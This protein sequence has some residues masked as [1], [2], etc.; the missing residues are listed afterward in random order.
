M[1]QYT[2]GMNS[3]RN[4]EGT[5]ILNRYGSELVLMNSWSQKASVSSERMPWY[6]VNISSFHHQL[7][8]S[9]KEYL[10]VVRVSM[11]LNQDRSWDL[12]TSNPLLK[13]QRVSSSA[14]IT[15]AFEI[16]EIAK[17]WYNAFCNSWLRSIRFDEG[18]YLEVLGEYIF[19]FSDVG[20][21]ILTVDG[22]SDRYSTG[23]VKNYRIVSKFLSCWHKECYII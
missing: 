9:Q 3:M 16:S 18:T 12:S 17:I 23:K 6:I 7:K 2:W 5:A 14:M 15:H 10:I 11:N 20:N 19:A 1:S 8:S 4:K 13:S 22:K 21:I